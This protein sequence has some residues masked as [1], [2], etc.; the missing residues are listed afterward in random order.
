MF[1][2]SLKYVL[3]NYQY[4]LFTYSYNIVSK[5]WGFGIYKK[6]VPTRSM[7][8]GEMLIVLRF[9]IALVNL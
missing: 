3:R 9:L 1:V 5:Y 6:K 8:K 2:L 4:F 7:E